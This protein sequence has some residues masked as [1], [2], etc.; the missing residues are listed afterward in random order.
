[1]RDAPVGE[2]RGRGTG[3]SLVTVERRRCEWAQDDA[4]MRAYH[5]R[6]WG[7]P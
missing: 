3:G 1:M 6:E 4:L 2:I 5:D 7:V